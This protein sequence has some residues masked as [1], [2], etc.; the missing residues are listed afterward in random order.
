MVIAGRLAPGLMETE[1]LGMAKNMEI[2]ERIEE[3]ETEFDV[4]ITVTGGGRGWT[5]SADGS[6]GG[7]PITA[8]ATSKADAIEALADLL[9]ANRDA[10]TDD[11]EPGEEF[12][13]CSDEC[14]SSTSSVC[15]CKCDGENHGSALGSKARVVSLGEKPCRCGCG[16]ITKREFVAGHDARFATMEAAKAAGQTVEEYRAA[17][18]VERNKRAAAKRRDKRAAIKAG[19]AK[20]AA[21]LGA[22]ALV[23]GTP[24][25]HG[26]HPDDDVNPFDI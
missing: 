16:G 10:D 19:A 5:A 26:V 21:A 3:V 4:E 6:F 1:A 17:L 11:A 2:A 22:G 13:G 20:V 8:K 15:Q 18:K 25:K 9:E 7:E 24:A 12:E 23:P 14:Q